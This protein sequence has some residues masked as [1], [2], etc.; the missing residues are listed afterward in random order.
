MVQNVVCEILN[1]NKDKKIGT[2]SYT[3]DYYQHEKIK[4]GINEPDISKLDKFSLDEIYN[5]SRK[6]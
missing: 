6:Y 3:S 5:E 4:S 1:E 2:K